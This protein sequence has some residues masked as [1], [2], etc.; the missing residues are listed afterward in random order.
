MINELLQR[1]VQ[2]CGPEPDLTFCAVQH[3]LH[4]AVTMLLAVH[5]RDE[6][7]EPIALERQESLRFLSWHDGHCVSYD[8]YMSQD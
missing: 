6:D 7:V 5:E 1:S 8:I 2:G 4:D 3:L